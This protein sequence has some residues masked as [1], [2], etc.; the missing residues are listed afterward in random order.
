[1]KKTRF[2]ILALAVAVMIMGAGYAAWTD[3]L[4]VNTTVDTGELS[5][6]F[7]GPEHDGGSNYYSSPRMF[8]LHSDAPGFEQQWNS[9]TPNDLLSGSVTY[10]DK[11]MT[12]T[13]SN[14]YPGTRGA[15]LYTIENNGTIPAVLQDITVTT[16]TLDDGPDDVANVEAAM[17]VTHSWLKIMRDGQEIDSQYIQS[18]PLADLEST[19]E[20]FFIGKRLQPDDQIVLGAP[21]FIDEDMGEIIPNTFNF[22]LPYDSLEGDEGELEAVEIDVQFD[23][24]Q[25]NMFD[26]SP[27]ETPEV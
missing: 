25:H 5:V 10:G 1:M 22:E 6:Q 20:G 3:S 7:V 23:F 12:F 15:G 17:M 26:P 13:F 9:A 27:E 4:A 2:L 24:V 16:N 19:L 8:Y 21:D 14:M 18:I 11:E